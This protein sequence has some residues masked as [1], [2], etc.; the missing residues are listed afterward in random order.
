MNSKKADISVKNADKATDVAAHSTAN[1]VAA[2]LQKANQLAQLKVKT[3][4]RGRLIFALD[5]TL[6]RQHTWDLACHIQ[7]EM[8]EA[9]ESV[10][11][12]DVQLN[13]FRGF[14]ECR[15]SPWVSETNTLHNYMGRISC[16]GGKTQIKKVLINALREQSRQSVDALVFI[17]DAM[18]ENLDILCDKAG[19]MGLLG[20]PIFVFQEGRDPTTERAFKEMARLS[21]GA[22]ARFDQASAQH[23]SDLL[24]AVAVYAAGGLKALE[25]SGDR[26]LLP[27][28]NGEG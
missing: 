6:S 1:E 21:N 10:G 24:K 20:V 3:N 15:S 14:R 26:L 5:A 28:L 8:F 7:A 18:E 11:G 4:R 16:K 19:E 23:L 22:Y 27:Q 13:Y 17:G 25:A 2:F 12:L 9:V